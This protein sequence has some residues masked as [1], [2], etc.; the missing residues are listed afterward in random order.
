MR[1]PGSAGVR[2]S[3]WVGVRMRVSGLA[4]VRV[5]TWVGVRMRVSGLAGVRVLAWLGWG[6][7]GLAG[8]TGVGWSA[9]DPD[10][11]DAAA[12]LRAGWCERDVGQ[13]ACRWPDAWCS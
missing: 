9:A 12:R 8:G 7:W 5:S 10:G 3:T 11:A 13:R 1:V 6:C 4:G 2:V